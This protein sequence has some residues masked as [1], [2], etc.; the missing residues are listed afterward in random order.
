MNRYALT[1]ALLLVGLLTVPVA[2]QE[3][4]T[5][6]CSSVV[7]C[8]P[9]PVP[10]PPGPQGPAG[11]TGPAG[12]QGPAGTPGLPGLPGPEGP[13]GPPGEHND[14]LCPPVPPIDVSLPGVDFSVSAVVTGPFCE[15]IQY[16]YLPQFGIAVFVDLRAATYQ[17]APHPGVVPSA[18]VA[19]P[20]QP[21]LVTI[22]SKTTGGFWLKN[23]APLVNPFAWVPLATLPGIQVIH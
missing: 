22:Y 4:L 15:I 12:P 13:Q 5:N 17:I 14:V 1:A 10:G 18:I 20:G 21:F 16:S 7:S 8:L 3:L 6:Y 2:A 23:L 9:P 11:P 19:V